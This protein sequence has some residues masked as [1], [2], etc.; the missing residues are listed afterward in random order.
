MNGLVRQPAS[1]SVTNKDSHTS[2]TENYTS[3]FTFSVS[4]MV[5]FYFYP[6]FDILILLVAHHLWKDMRSIVQNLF[7]TK[8]RYA[9]SRKM[10][11]FSRT[12]MTFWTINFKQ[13]KYVIVINDRDCR[14]RQNLKT[15]TFRRYQ[16]VD[17]K[18]KTSFRVSIYIK[19]RVPD[20]KQ[21]DVLDNEFLV[22]TY[23]N[24]TNLH[25]NITTG[26]WATEAK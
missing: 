20:Q 26:S 2:N 24:Q 10:R 7:L 1:Q 5:L 11:V 13:L 16:T 12:S 14:P 21:T 15:K 8:W 18:K 9:K 3:T 6:L 23:V 4:V 19:I 22:H 17:R 25:W